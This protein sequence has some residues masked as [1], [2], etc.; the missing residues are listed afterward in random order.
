MPQTTQ[1]GVAPLNPQPLW[2]GEY[3]TVLPEA[4]AQGKT[5]PYLNLLIHKINFLG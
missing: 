3:N 5:L 2:P 1:R 4:G